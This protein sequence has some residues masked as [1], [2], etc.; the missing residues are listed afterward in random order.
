MPLMPTLY[1]VRVV[2]R[3]PALAPWIF[4]LR[5]PDDDPWVRLAALRAHVPSAPNTSWPTEGW[6]LQMETRCPHC[7]ETRLVT[8]EKTYKGEELLCAVC[9]KAAPCVRV[10]GPIDT[11]LPTSMP[12]S[13]VL[14]VE[15]P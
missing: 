15:R 3:H 7:G 12:R 11:S 13:P 8:I 4:Y 10:A 1:R 6:T 9:G 5:S 2:A 14:G